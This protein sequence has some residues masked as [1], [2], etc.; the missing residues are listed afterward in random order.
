MDCGFHLAFSWRRSQSYRDWS[1][2]LQSKSMDWFLYDWDLRHDRVKEKLLS[3][4][5]FLLKWKKALKTSLKLKNT[6]LDWIWLQFNKT[7]TYFQTRAPFIQTK[8]GF[9]S[10]ESQQLA[11]NKFWL[12]FVLLDW[13]QRNEWKL[14]PRNPLNSDYEIVPQ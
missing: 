13:Q 3:R 5:R 10:I 12:Y 4:K 14:E 7:I 11:E 1:I 6:F 8:I 9:Q 2:D